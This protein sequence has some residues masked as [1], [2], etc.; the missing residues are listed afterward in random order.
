MELLGGLGDGGFELGVGCAG[1]GIDGDGFECGIGGGGGGGID[2]DALVGGRLSEVDGIRGGG[3]DALSADQG[4]LAQHSG[5]RSGQRLQA[6][7]GVPEAQV[8]AVSH[9]GSF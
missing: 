4:E 2:V 1:D 5:E 8:E 7:V 3:G 6:E 9:D